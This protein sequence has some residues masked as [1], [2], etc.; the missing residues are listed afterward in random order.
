MGS[1]IGA[2]F[3]LAFIKGAITYC[4]LC[5][6]RSELKLEFHHVDGS[7]KT[8]TASN[9]RKKANKC[10]LMLLV[11]LIKCVPLCKSCHSSF[12]RMNGDNDIKRDHIS[13]IKEYHSYFNRPGYLFGYSLSHIMCMA[14]L[15]IEFAK[16]KTEWTEEEYFKKIDEVNDEYAGTSLFDLYDR[17]DDPDN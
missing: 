12:T 16:K 5:G 2:D 3:F 17:D 11:E 9:L 8:D 13:R 1:T 4:I 14:L 15:H 6:R 10:V 7:D